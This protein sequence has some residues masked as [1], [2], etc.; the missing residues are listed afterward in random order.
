MEKPVLQDGMTDKEALSLN[1]RR[2]SYGKG[3]GEPVGGIV[4]PTDA[5][6]GGRIDIGVAPLGDGGQ[7]AGPG[8]GPLQ[9]SDGGA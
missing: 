8:P 1:T 9:A 3:V 7:H 4:K 2:E 5:G 6:R